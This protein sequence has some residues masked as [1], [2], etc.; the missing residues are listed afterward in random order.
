M[1]PPECMEVKFDLFDFLRGYQAY[2]SA[3]WSARNSSG[4]GAA[5]LPADFFFKEVDD[6]ADSNI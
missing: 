6:V 1:Q 4:N 2:E 3:M 5:E